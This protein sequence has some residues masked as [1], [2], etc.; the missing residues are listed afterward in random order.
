MMITFAA[1][2]DRRLLGAALRRAFRPMLFFYWSLA[3]LML[4][5]SL[6]AL[7]GGDPLGVV[8]FGAGAVVIGLIAWWTDRRTV[9][10][11][12]K[13]YGLPIPAHLIFRVG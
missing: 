8:I 1:Q 2:P 10:V 5:A 6:L 12:W 13:F 7:C 4:V 9:T 3:A 11:N